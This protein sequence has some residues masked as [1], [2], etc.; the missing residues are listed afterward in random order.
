MLRM[1]AARRLLLTTRHSVT[2]V[3]LEVGY[4]SVGSFTYQFT[5]LLGLS[6]SRLRRLAA[7]AAHELDRQRSVASDHRPPVPFGLGLSGRVEAT[8]AAPGP[9]FVGLFRAPRPEGRPIASRGP[10]TEPASTPLIRRELR[11]DA[12]R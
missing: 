6:P 2:D 3:C 11:L 5:E 12:G 8:D 1:E 10:E 4:S 7:R 9:I